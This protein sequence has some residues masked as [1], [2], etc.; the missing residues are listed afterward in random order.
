MAK[1]EP[2]KAMSL[3]L[4]GE[5]MEELARVA[6]VEG[7]T[8]SEVVRNAIREWIDSRGTDPEFQK[9]VKKKL[10]ED[11]AVFKRLAGKADEADAG[12]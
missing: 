11:I 8:V 12:E 9:Q 6:R 1:K 4:D 7:S 5:K 2:T 10:E 3:R